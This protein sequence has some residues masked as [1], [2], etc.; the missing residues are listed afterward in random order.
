MDPAYRIRAAL[1]F[2]KTEIPPVRMFRGAY[3]GYTL[4]RF[5]KGASP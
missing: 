1:P 4:F 2:R 5:E 3:N